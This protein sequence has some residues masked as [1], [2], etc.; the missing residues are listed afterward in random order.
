MQPA[1]PHPCQRRSPPPIRLTPRDRDLIDAVHSYRALRRD[2][3]QRLFFPSKNTANARL[4]RLQQH[5]Y[6]ARR[7]LPVE[8]GQGSGQWLYMLAR[9]GAQLVAQAEGIGIEEIGWRRSQCHVSSMFLE[10]RLMVN[11]IRIAMALATKQTG[12]R[13]ERWLREEDLKKQPDRVW[14]ASRRGRRR[15]V[16]L[17]PDAYCTLAEDDRRAHFFLEADRAT[18]SN[19]RWSQKVEA[20]L[21]YIR[22]G[23]YARRYGSNCLRVLT[24]TTGEK[25]LHNLM[26]STQRVG[27]GAMFWFATLGQTR[28]ETI[29]KAPIWWIAGQEAPSA[30]LSPGPAAA[31]VPMGSPILLYRS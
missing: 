28:P 12:A 9:R 11:D 15:R 16:A 21:A 26:R 19:G 17:I 6:L 8:Y 25:R 13:I 1:P 18:E 20:Y 23:G 22:S 31:T 29:L 4:Q 14:I 5:G 24:V 3:V 30:L 27:G 7:R 2:Q 10:H